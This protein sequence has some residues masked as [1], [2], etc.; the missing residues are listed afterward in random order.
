M[1]SKNNKNHT[2]II[3]FNL[4][5]F[6]KVCRMKPKSNRKNGIIY[7]WLKT[8]ETPIISLSSSSNKDSGYCRKT[9][10]TGK[11]DG[12]KQNHVVTQ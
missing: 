8:V 2:Q 3:N 5:N 4:F 7:L 10:P 9:T 12:L 11:N 6:F 1:L